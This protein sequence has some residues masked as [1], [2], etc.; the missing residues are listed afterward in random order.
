M[1][2]EDVDRA[3]QFRKLAEKKD[4]FGKHNKSDT[5][6]LNFFLRECKRMKLNVFGP[7][8]NK[9]GISFTVDPKGEIRFGL[10]ALKGLGIGPAEEIING[11]VAV[12]L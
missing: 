10:S 12:F 2:K 9:S 3:Y 4:D 6:K 11:R 5:S 8:I 1:N 7:D